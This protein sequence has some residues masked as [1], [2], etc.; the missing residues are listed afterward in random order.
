MR[1]SFNLNRNAFRQSK[2]FE[3][4]FNVDLKNSSFE[5]ILIDTLEDDRIF[6]MTTNLD[7]Q[8]HSINAF[9]TL[10]FIHDHCYDKTRL[11]GYDY[12]LWNDPMARAVYAGVNDD[13]GGLLH[14]GMQ[15]KEF[16]PLSE[17]ITANNLWPDRS[18]IR[19]KRDNSMRGRLAKPFKKLLRTGVAK[20]SR[21][22]FCS[23]PYNPTKVQARGYKAILDAIA[24]HQRQDLLELCEKYSDGRFGK[25][26][27]PYA[28]RSVAEYG[29]D[30]L[31]SIGA[32][33]ALRLGMEAFYKGKYK[34][35]L[36]EKSIPKIRYFLDILIGLIKTK[37]T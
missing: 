25:V 19:I 24:L 27:F 8:V 32:D 21:G 13:D 15:S 11:L 18:D 2:I 9:F 5:Q 31:M 33:N 26:I 22:R 35:G 4:S 23:T 6:E 29:P 16:Y 3:N 36:K 30:H 7:P 12:T 17:F 20:L 1:L 14:C 37:S 10:F 28:L 34:R